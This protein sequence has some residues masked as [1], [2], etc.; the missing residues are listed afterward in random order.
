MTHPGIIYWIGTGPGD[1][2]LL[3]V[4]GLALLQAADAVVCNAIAQAGLLAHIRSEATLLDVGSRAGGNHLGADEINRRLIELASTGQTV[5]RLWSGDPFVFGRAAQEMA[6]ARAAGVRVA[7][8]PGVSSAIAVPGYAGVPLT[9]A[10]YAAGFA[11]V[12]GP[13]SSRARVEVNWPALAGIDTLVILQPLDNLPEIVAHLRAAGRADDTPALAIH[14]GTL[15]AQRQVRTTLAQ[16]VDA[17]RA[18]AI[19]HPAMVVVGPVAAL[20]DE[21]HWFEPGDYPLLGQRVLVTRPAHQAAEFVA[22]LRDLGAEPIVFPTIRI[23]STADSGELDAAIGRVAGETGRRI[24][25]MSFRPAG[26]E[27]PYDWLV[28]TSA[29]GVTAFWERM[30][31]LGLDARSLASVKIVAIGPATAA[32]LQRYSLTPDLVPPVY[33]AEGV[34]E[35]IDQQ[36]PVAGQR[37]LLARADIARKTLAQGLVQRGAMVDEIPAYRTVP[38]PDGPPP[39]HADIVIFTSSSTVQGFVN[40]LGGRAPAEVLRRSRVVCIGPITAA[41]A[42]ELGVPVTMVAEDYT[43]NGILQLLKEATL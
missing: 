20:A 16:L 3:T 15:P 31:A 24:G 35:A 14:G 7:L 10:D 30:Q 26:D 1:P 9:H 42:I 40:C 37:F 34:L 41:T 33:T 13:P 21:L 32:M 43:I 18:H 38:V 4:K 28:L 19:D 12:T 2:G 11:V 17:V 25:Q 5:A 6:A 27:P 23:E 29:N 36:G 39:P 22:A 8:V